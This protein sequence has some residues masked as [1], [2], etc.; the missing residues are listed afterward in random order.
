MRRHGPLA[1]ASGWR[2]PHRV[3]NFDIDFEDRDLIATVHLDVD[4]IGINFDMA[5][6]GDQDFLAQNGK[7]IRG[8][9]VLPR[10]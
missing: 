6:D 4:A 9:R 10:S 3:R 1:P 2:H 8:P 7:K 5:A